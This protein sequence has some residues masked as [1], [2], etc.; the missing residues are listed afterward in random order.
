[1]QNPIGQFWEFIIQAMLNARRYES[2]PFQKAL[3]MRVGTA[4]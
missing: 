3:N 2:E 1:M 4:V